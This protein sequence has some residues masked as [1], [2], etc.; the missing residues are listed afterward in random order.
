MAFPC[1][2][3][4]HYASGEG[5]VEVIALGLLPIPLASGPDVT[6]SSR[7][8]LIAEAVWCPT[9]LVHPSVRWE[10]AGA[11]RAR[12]TLAVDGDAVAV[13]IQV[14]ASGRVEEVTLD[15]WGDPDG[16]PARLVPYGF[17]VDAESAFGGIT[18]PT[19][20][21]GGWFYGTNR[22]DPAGAAHFTVH[23]A[24]FAR[25]SGARAATSDPRRVASQ[26]R[27]RVRCAP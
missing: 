21:V 13:T 8:H 16:G 15:R 5:G 23:R 7:G 11:D 14:D 19:H 24:A 6:R 9:A 4:D 27:P 12:F 2:C 1:A 25:A 17:R 18:I 26:P 10:A 3:A 20:L 22:F